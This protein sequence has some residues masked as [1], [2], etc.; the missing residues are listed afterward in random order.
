MLAVTGKAV[1]PA[2]VG[3]GPAD[4]RE[5]PG[6]ARRP[7]AES[8]TASTVATVHRRARELIRPP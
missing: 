2:V 4:R 3:V 7:H 6:A 5:G 1:E 8:T